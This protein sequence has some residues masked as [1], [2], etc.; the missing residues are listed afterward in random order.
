MD[1]GPAVADSS[2][3][4]AFAKSRKL[5]WLLDAFKRPLLI[6]SAVYDE[7]VVRGLEKKEADA[8]LIADAVKRK[9]ITVLSPKKAP[10]FLFLGAGESAVISLALGR[11]IQNVCI[12][13]APARNAAKRL[14]LRPV[15]T[16]GVIA[17]LL[18]RK[19]INQT[20]ALS[21]VD[22]MVRRDFRISAKVL[23]RFRKEITV[24]G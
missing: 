24:L 20:Q 16:L 22:G 10:P 19:R 13:E 9:A 12:D 14:G 1:K 4:I 2:V 6:P 17:V 18:K 7:A 23:A 21:A 3:L 15:G 5:D 11:R 8:A